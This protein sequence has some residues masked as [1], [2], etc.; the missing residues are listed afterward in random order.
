MK[1]SL[2][3]VIIYAWEWLYL[4][5]AFPGLQNK[6]VIFMLHRM[7]TPDRLCDG[8]SDEFLN[9]ALTYLSRKGYNFV[10]LEEVFKN[11]HDG[12]PLPNKAIAFTID[13][14]FIDQATIAAPIF[15]KHQ[16]PVTIFLITGF[17]DNG[18]PPWDA[19]LKYVFYKMDKSQITVKIKSQYFTY[20]IDTPE[21][22]YNSMNDFRNKCKSLS[23]TELNQTLRHMATELGL[24]G[25][26]MP[27]AG[28]QALS[29]KDALT[30][31]KSGISFSPHTTSH[32][33][34]SNYSDKRAHE[35]ITGSWKR[36]VNNLSHPCPVFAYPNGQRKD[37]TMRDINCIKE[38]GLLGAVTAEPGYVDSSKITEADR[39]LIKRMSFPSGLECLIQYCTG[40][41][42]VKQYYRDLKLKYKHAG[43]IRLLTDS[44]LNIKYHLG[45]FNKYE[46]IDWT[47]ITRLVFVCKGNICRSP[48]AEIRARAL[49]INSVSIGLDTTEGSLADADAASIASYR[50]IDLKQHRART[51]TSIEFSS[52]DLVVCMEPW[53]LKNFNQMSHDHSQ[54]TLL[55]LWC[56]RKKAIVTD[57]YGKPD[58][59]FNDCFITIDDALNNI[60][61]LLEQEKA[62]SNDKNYIADPIVSA[63]STHA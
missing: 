55:G 60:S 34:L 11:I 32:A 10:S 62:M 52:N 27:I 19:F 45:G 50:G 14:G 59:F 33:I 63:K 48:Y 15:I 44:I 1:Y 46:N 41:E 30:L 43:R 58:L 61:N 2:K 38:L 47:K 29:W 36:L 26:H 16:C 42:F 18:S 25:R 57:P 51:Y 20:K 40:L 31:E 21:E 28:F 17:I 12:S 56:S 9:Q 7:A 4:A 37:F 6:T 22:R 8:H 3:K 39:Y 5:G 54:A 49:G 23:E 35:E 13:D 53:Q 24:E